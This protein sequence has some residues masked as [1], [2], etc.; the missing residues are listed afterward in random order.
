M[1][2]F[3][4]LSW[5]VF[6]GCHVSGGAAVVELAIENPALGQKRASWELQR[7]CIMVS[8]SGARSIWLSQGLKA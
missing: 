6:G 4:D 1:Q 7:R 8:S 3:I 2:G 5:D